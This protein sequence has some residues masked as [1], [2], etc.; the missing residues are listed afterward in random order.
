M[1][2]FSSLCIG[3]LII[4]FL[5]HTF[6]PFPYGNGILGFLTLFVLF[7]LIPRTKLFPRIMSLLM[8]GVGFALLIVYGNI[9]NWSE[10]ITLNLPLVILIMVVPLLSIPLRLGKYDRAI[11]D[12]IKQY[13]R[14]PRKL[15]FSIMSIFFILGPII[16]LGSIRLIDS[17]LGKLNLPKEFLAKVYM[18]GF[19]SVI[20]WAPFFA[21]VL[22][23]LFLLEVPLLHYLPFGFGLGLIQLVVASLFFYFESKRIDW[24]LEVGS[25]VKYRKLIELLVI[26]LLFFIL[27]FSLDVLLN[28]K[29]IV[30]VTISSI[31]MAFIWSIYLKEFWSFTRNLNVYRKDTILLSANEFIMFIT[32]GFFGAVVAGTSVGEWINSGISTLSNTSVLLMIISIIFVTSLLAFLG[33][34]QIVTISAI[35]TSVSTMDG[36]VHS[37]VFALTF[38]SA[39]A[40]ATMVSP[41]TP[42]NVILVN[43]IKLNFIQI[44]MKWNGLF[45][46]LMI[47]VYSI[48]I[49][50]IYLFIL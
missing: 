39:W 22:L 44:S 20:V 25:K 11:S 41:I 45:A 3:V 17:L 1:K 26:F 48:S 14:N 46:L 49:Y 21:A 37:I 31:I 9:G 42:V 40:V 15:Y 34:H 29:M 47:G 7:I 32:A 18:R 10:S 4:A 5:T 36:N 43:V 12:F 6:F 23:V 33:V 50:L 16:N 2:H 38:M 19:T 13:G 30:I 28:I 35:A 27:V 24:S 8:L